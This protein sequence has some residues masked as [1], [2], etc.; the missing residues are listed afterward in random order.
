MICN[1][2]FYLCDFILLIK[3]VIFV[4]T[5]YFVFLGLIFLSDAFLIVFYPVFEAVSTCIIP[6]TRDAGD[7]LP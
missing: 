4:T 1:F 2:L 3:V 5:F 7:L 6:E